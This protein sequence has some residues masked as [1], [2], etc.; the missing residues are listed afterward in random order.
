SGFNV[1]LQAFSS[2]WLHLSPPQKYTI[3]QQTTL[4][5]YS[6]YRNNKCWNLF[7]RKNNAMKI[8][9]DLI[10]CGR[11]PILI[12]I[13]TIP[14]INSPKMLGLYHNTSELTFSYSHPEE[15]K[16]STELSLTQTL[17]S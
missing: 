14:T 15:H 4:F 17:S 13:Y 7:L 3:T 2:V 10:D 5:I 16:A 12:N 6:N 11:M 8:Q 9:W 1:F